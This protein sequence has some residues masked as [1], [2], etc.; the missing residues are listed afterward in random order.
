MFLAD[1]LIY[2][3]MQKTG[4]THITAVLNDRLGG[5][6]R[7][8]HQPLPRPPEGQ[9]VLSSVRDPY[10]WYVSLWAY[11]A[12]ERGGLHGALTRGR[13]LDAL[14]ADLRGAAPHPGRMIH[15]LR[16]YRARKPTAAKLWRALYADPHDVTLFRRW[17]TH[18]LSEEGKRDLVEGYGES[19]LRHVAGF[20]TYRFL[21]LGTPQT[22]WTTGH[23]AI[24]TYADL[25]A[26]AERHHAV[27]DVIKMEALESD[28]ARVLTDLGHPTSAADLLTRKKTNTSKRLDV[29]AYYDD[30]TRALVADAERWIIERYGY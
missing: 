13:A 21:R 30:A 14:R 6:E 16:A 23:G 1:G 10:D 25:C 4:C 24:R 15:A 28:L 11:G 22:V 19:P 29:R 7:T 12:S 5:Q 8:K 27:Q 9:L 17:L 26:Y 3:Q 18:L 20:M 2:L